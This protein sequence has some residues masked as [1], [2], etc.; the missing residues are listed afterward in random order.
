VRVGIMLDL[1]TFPGERVD[2]I[3]GST[4]ELCEEADRLGIAGLW[5]SEHHGFDDGYLPQPL[6]FAAAV[7]ART[8]RA[9]I[10]TA[11]L[12]AFL[13]PA[14]DVA[15]Q[16]AIVDAISAGRM[17]L[18]LGAGYRKVEADLYGASFAH[19]F[20]AVDE[21]TRE[22]RRIWEE[23]TARPSPTQERPLI[24]LGYQGPLGARRAGRLGEGR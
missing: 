5:M 4:L 3:Y 7:A 10:G 22:V 19:R 14:V 20:D 21:R 17:E 11:V 6:A 18:G 9:R 16:A 24:W 8:G 13:R 2:H 15:E 1:R 23:G 12:N